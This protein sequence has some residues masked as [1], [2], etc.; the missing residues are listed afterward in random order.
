MILI[1]QVLYRV[2]TYT[3]AGGIIMIMKCPYC[4]SDNCEAEWVD[5]EVGFIQCGPYICLDCGASEIGAYDKT[6]ATELEKE[7]GWY[8]PDNHSEHVSTISGKIINSAEALALYRA[9]VVDKIPFN[10]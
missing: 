1:L 6:P 9:G 7:K 4:D 10:I 5:V 8:A 2:L 3:I